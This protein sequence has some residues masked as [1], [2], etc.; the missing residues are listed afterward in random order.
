L[1]RISGRQ[2]VACSHV[3]VIVLSLMFLKRKPPKLPE[4]AVFDNP[5]AI[6]C[7]SPGKPSQISAYTL[8]I[9]EARVIGL[10][11][12][13]RQYG[14]IFIRLAV[15]ASQKCE[16]AQNSMTICTYSSSRSSKV[17]DFGTNQKRT[18]D[19]LLVINSNYGPIL[20]RFWDTATY[21][22]KIAIFFIPLCCLAPPLPMF[23]L[24]FR[25]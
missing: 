22:L 1:Q 15:V 11:F 6:W 9:S 3:I 4:I 2:G 24:E 19:F 12:C 20:H 17:I 8:H 25:G 16:L 5:T 23:R 13:S 7:P 21:W 18:Y 10:H 14:S